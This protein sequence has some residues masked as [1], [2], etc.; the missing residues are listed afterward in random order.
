MIKLHP[1]FKN[2]VWKDIKNRRIRPPFVPDMDD[3]IT[4]VNNELME[5]DQFKGRGS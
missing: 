4:Q 5:D 3:L 1:F 2:I